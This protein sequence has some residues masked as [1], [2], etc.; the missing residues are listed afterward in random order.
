MPHKKNPISAEN[1]CGI[2]RLLRGNA[3][4]SMEDQALWHERDISHSSVERVIMPDSTILADY[5]LTRLTSLLDNLVVH[6]EQMLK[7]MELSFGLYFSQRVLTALV[8][9]GMDRQKAYEAIQKLAMK[10]WREHMR[11]PELV[12]NDED[13]VR[14]LGKE[15]L[16]DL[17]D[18]AAYLACE[19][20]IFG[21]VFSAEAEECQK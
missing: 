8:E 21:R 7:N 2:S 10:S 16:D 1:I 17:F 6:P 11:F 20:V 3:L 18:P 4:A 12:A 14:I 15:K 5:A 13:M 19:E 9:A